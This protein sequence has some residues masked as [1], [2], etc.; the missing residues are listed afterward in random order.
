MH[1]QDD[2]LRLCD[3][4]KRGPSPVHYFNISLQSYQLLVEFQKTNLGPSNLLSYYWK[5]NLMS[6][7]TSQTIEYI[8]KGDFE[9]PEGVFKKAFDLIADDGELELHLPFNLSQVI[10]YLLIPSLNGTF[11]A[12]VKLITGNLNIKE[13]IEYTNLCKDFKKELNQ[14]G[15]FFDFNISD[16]EIR[17]CSERLEC[18]SNMK[19][20]VEQS[21]A[22]LETANV[23]GLRGEF[24]NVK[25]IK[26]KVNHL[27]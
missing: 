17:G 14:L 19:T 22:I 7:A 11:Q 20:C 21:N 10:M 4:Y 8:P 1:T 26:S 25:K 13:A 15:S 24:S 9:H 12:M 2:A 5:R 27:Y 18:A 16:S 23:L 6:V 3:I